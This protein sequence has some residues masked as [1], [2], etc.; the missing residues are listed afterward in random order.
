MT[1]NPSD[2]F[3]FCLGFHLQLPASVPKQKPVMAVYAEQAIGS[4]PAREMRAVVG[5]LAA[6]GG[7]RGLEQP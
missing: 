2:D 7:R 6:E 3:H 5:R 1:V 4:L